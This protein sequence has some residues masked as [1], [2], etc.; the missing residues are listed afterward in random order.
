MES[1]L[2]SMVEE[3]SYSVCRLMDRVYFIKDSDDLESVG[4]AFFEA[5]ALEYETLVSGTRNVNC[6]RK[7]INFAVEAQKPRVP[8]RVLDF[9]CGT[10][11]STKALE[12]V[13]PRVVGYDGSAAMRELTK[14]TG[15]IVIDSLDQC[16]SGSIDLVVAC[17]VMHFGIHESD[18]NELSRILQPQGAIVANFH[19]KIALDS[20]TNRL[21]R[22][23]FS[24]GESI[25]P[26]FSEF[27]PI[28]LFHRS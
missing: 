6:A 20:V 25:H 24:I 2:A 14:A 18:A 28:V 17:Y 10:G 11:L 9:G 4:I 21:E 27:G 22:V 1:V 12:E 23:G 5:I 13:V 19:K 15:S 7:L 16:S 8:Q 26:S 3:S